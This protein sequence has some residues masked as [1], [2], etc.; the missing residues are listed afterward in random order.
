MLHPSYLLWHRYK[1]YIHVFNPYNVIIHIRNNEVGDIKHV[2]TPIVTHTARSNM[3][4]FQ[5]NI[6][7]KHIGIRY[8]SI[9]VKYCKIKLHPSYRLWHQVKHYIY[10]FNMCKVNICFRSNVI[11]AIKHINT[12]LVI[13]TT[14]YNVLQF[15]KHTFQ[16]H[17]TF[18]ILNLTSFETIYTCV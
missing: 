1:Q 14:R 8:F 12:H 10:V 15:E 7:E 4:Q 9:L 2:H 11:G 18:I 13:Y 6:S 5:K 16:N 17:V 3:L